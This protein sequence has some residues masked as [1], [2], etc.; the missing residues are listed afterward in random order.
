MGA[1][2]IVVGIDETRDFLTRSNLRADAPGSL[3]QTHRWM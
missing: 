1:L 2:N 3:R